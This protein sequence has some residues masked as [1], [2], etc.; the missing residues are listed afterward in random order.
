MTQVRP[1]LGFIRLIVHG[2]VDEVRALLRDDSALATA[3]FV[4]GAKREDASE[5]FFKEIAHYIYAG[6]TPLHMAAAA[7]N[8]EIAKLLID[9]GADLRARNRR[10]AEPLHYAADANHW[11]PQRQAATIACLISAGADPNAKDKSGVA[12]LHRAVRTRSGE[13]VKALLDGGAD[14]ALPNGSGSTPLKLARLPTGRSGSGSERARE[15]QRVIEQ[16]LRERL[17]EVVTS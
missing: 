15:Q 10:G 9:A 17:T 14:P 8:R 12:P 2:K 1:L 3:V 5:Y 6:D 7:F 13:A 4:H 11:D 16:L